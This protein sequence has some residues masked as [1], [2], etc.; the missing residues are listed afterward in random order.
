MIGVDLQFKINMDLFSTKEIVNDNDVLKVKE[1]I[2]SLSNQICELLYQE[3]ART[4][5][6]S[7]EVNLDYVNYIESDD[8]KLE[9]EVEV[10]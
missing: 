1:I 2:G 9:L 6:D 8:L 10:Q 3:F 4:E 7:V 5:F